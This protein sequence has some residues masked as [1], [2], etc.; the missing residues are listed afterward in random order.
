MA[1]ADFSIVVPF[2]FPSGSPVNRTAVEISSGKACLLLA[3]PPDL[4]CSVPNDY[5]AS[6]SLAG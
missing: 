6:P 1:S 2:G 5:W 4:P 3:D